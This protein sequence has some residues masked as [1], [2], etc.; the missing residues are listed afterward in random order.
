MPP[1]E[2]T[3]VTGPVR[4]TLRLQELHAIQN[5]EAFGQAE[6]TLRLWING[7]ER[8]A[9]EDQIRVAAGKTAPIGAE[10]VT[11]VP[12]YTDEIQVRVEATEHDLLSRDE[13]ASGETRLLRIAGFEHARPVVIDIRGKGAR[14][15]IHADVEVESLG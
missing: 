13:H 7:L 8:W 11:E 3:P 10:I 15:E 1:I 6:W 4:V 2:P 14:I 5:P 12:E 9:T